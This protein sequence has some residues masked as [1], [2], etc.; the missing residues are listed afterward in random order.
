MA[1]GLPVIVAD[2]DNY[3]DRVLPGETGW[4]APSGAPEELADRIVRAWSDPAHREK[5][6]KAAARRIL[7]G[8]TATEMT[9]SFHRLYQGLD[10]SF[11]GSSRQGG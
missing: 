6:T 2:L 3:R 7:D 1:V 4:V 10:R 8:Y 9:D 5:I 11:R